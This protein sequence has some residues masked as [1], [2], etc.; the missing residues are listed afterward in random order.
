MDA[1]EFHPF[2]NAFPMMSDQEFAELVADIKAHGLQEDISIYRGKIID[3]RNRYRA[4][5]ELGLNI[6]GFVRHIDAA[7]DGGSGRLNNDEEALAFVISKNLVRR[8]LDET[9]RAMVA[10]RLSGLKPG[11]HA[12]QGQALPIGRV[13]KML[14]VG[15]RS[16][17]RA[18]KVIDKGAPE[19]VAAVERG[20]IAV[21]KAAKQIDEAAA[22]IGR[23]ASNGKA[24]AHK[25]EAKPD[26]SDPVAREIGALWAKVSPEMK[27]LIEHDDYEPKMLDTLLESVRV[28]LAL[29]YLMHIESDDDWM[30]EIET[31]GV[32]EFRR[33]VDRMNGLI[34]KLDDNN[35]PI[36]TKADRAEAKAKGGKLH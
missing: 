20:E 4:I 13:A 3:G 32:I 22:P 8:H 21:S 24:E 12:D 31:V 27:A 10:A 35:S 6:D 5:V 29:H 33:H 11:Q 7:E 26:T 1:Y 16:V 18:R 30:C 34:K 2:A 9:Q 17:A 25:P 14:N 19:L 36:K 28:R 23:A 15:E